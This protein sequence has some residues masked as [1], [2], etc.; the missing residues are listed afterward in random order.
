MTDKTDIAA[1]MLKMRN[2]A[3]RIIDA[4][5]ENNN[6]E[7]GKIIEM[8]DAADTTFK[9]ENVLLV[10]NALEAERQQGET[11]DRSAAAERLL[12]KASDKAFNE[13]L[14]RAEAAE[15]ERDDLKSAH[16]NM[17]CRCALLRQRTDLPV[18][19][20]PAYNALVKAQE[21]IAAMKAQL[22]NPVVLPA[23]YSTRNGHPFNE[24]ERNVMIPNKHGDWLS[25]FDVEHAIHVAGFTVKGE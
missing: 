23:G 21:E 2:L 1:L 3:D 9:A 22:V 15:K 17:V 19:R 11:A 24:G 14:E 20:V 13:Q 8:Y 4:E 5:G 7:V 12:R 10:L 25:R 16:G 18:D 6:G